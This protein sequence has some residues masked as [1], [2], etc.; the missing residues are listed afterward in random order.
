MSLLNL[1]DHKFPKMMSS[2]MHSNQIL[3][4]FSFFTF[5]VCIISLGLVSSFSNQDPIILS[6][7]VDGKEIKSTKLPPP[8]KL[9]AEG[10]NHYLE[11]RYNWNPSDVKNQLQKSAKFI[12]PQ[13]FNAFTEAMNIVEKFSLEKQVSQKVFV[14]NVKVNLESSTVAITGDRI[15]SIQGMKAAG[16]LKLILNFESGSR[17]KDNPWGI[18]ITKEREE[19]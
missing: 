7:D 3:K 18:Y 14:S 8:E 16:D 15:T 19:L 11:F 17:T 12:S 4:M 5:L 13:S 2:L 10:V 1:K 6:F 9:I